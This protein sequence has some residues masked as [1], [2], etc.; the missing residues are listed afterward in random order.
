MDKEREEVDSGG[1]RSGSRSSDSD[2]ERIAEDEQNSS[3]MYKE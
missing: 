3:G 2:G 1:R